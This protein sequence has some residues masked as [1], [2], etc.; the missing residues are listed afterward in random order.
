MENSKTVTINI[1]DKRSPIT[2]DGD[3]GM[4]VIMPIVVQT[5]EEKR[6]AQMRKQDRQYEA[7]VAKAKREEAEAKKEA[8]A[9]E[10]QK[11]EDGIAHDFLMSMKPMEAGRARKTL[12]KLIR[13]DGEVMEKKDFIAKLHDKGY[14]PEYSEWR[15]YS[16]KLDRNVDKKGWSMVQKDNSTGA[17]SGAYDITATESKFAQFLQ[18]NQ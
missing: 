6:E 17:V 13:Y 14:S 4:T 18:N 1:K 7:N 10:R 15:E 9:L 2:V 16:R 11:E 5:K 12:S 8:E 3:H